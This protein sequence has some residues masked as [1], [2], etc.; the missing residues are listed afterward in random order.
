MNVAVVKVTII[1]TTGPKWVCANRLQGDEK[2]GNW[3]MST[4]LETNRLTLRTWQPSDLDAFHAVCADARVMQFVGDGQPW[5]LEKTQQFIEHALA[6]SKTDGYCQWP[7]VHKDSD[8]LI[9]FCGFI[10]TDH[11]AEIGWR[12]AHDYWGQGLA[13]EAAHA[14]LN[15]GFDVLEFERVVATVQSENWASIRVVQKLGMKPNGEFQ[16]EG[17]KILVFTAARVTQQGT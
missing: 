1:E 8:N 10:P 4:I 11:V 5:S 12:L 13:T 15:Y 6:T 2:H 3:N 7:V 9:G 17:R 16:R 14:T